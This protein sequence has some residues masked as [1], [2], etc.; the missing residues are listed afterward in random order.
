MQMQMKMKSVNPFLRTLLLVALIFFVFA[1]LCFAQTTPALKYDGSDQSI[2]LGAN[3]DN[4]LN[5]IMGFFSGPYMKAI[6]LIALGALG[7]GMIMSRGEP[8]MVKK[9]IPWMAGVTILLSL[10]TIVN[11]FFNKV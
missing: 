3:M 7:I 2:S 10:S 6:C 9:F 8:G 1:P 5:K 4:A 11:L